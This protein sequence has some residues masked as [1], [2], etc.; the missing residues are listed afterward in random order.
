MSD[1]NVELIEAQPI[2]VNISDAQPINVHLADVVKIVEGEDKHYTQDF[3]FLA[4]VTVNHNLEKKPAVT[5]IDSAG[6]EV[7]GDVKHIDNNQLIV[8]FNAENTG[9]VFC[10]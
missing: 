7:V 2:D 4:A 3:T 5:V 8:T 9:T 6:D 1:I 10:N